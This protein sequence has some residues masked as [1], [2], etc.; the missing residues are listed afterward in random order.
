[1]VYYDP[2]AKSDFADIFIGLVTWEKHP[3]EYEHAMS[4]VTDIQNICDTLD[5]RTRHKDAAYR[6]HLRYGSKVFPYKRN[7]RTTWYIIYDV[8]T[9]N[10]VFI[11]KIISNYLTVDGL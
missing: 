8:D 10:N 4:Y 9:F 3:L 11:N 5:T 6:T 7:N 2:A 1:M